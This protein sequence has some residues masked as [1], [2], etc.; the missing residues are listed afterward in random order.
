MVGHVGDENR[1]LLRGISGLGE[2]SSLDGGEMF[3]DGVDLGDGRAGVDERAVG[4]D[5]I[6]QRDFVVFKVARRVFRRWTTRRRRA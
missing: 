1:N 2:A 3:A 5:E 4:G 6:G